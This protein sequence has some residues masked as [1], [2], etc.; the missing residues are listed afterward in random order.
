ML[1]ILLLR[2]DL[3]ETFLDSYRA[4]KAASVYVTV[5]SRAQ[6]EYLTKEMSDGF[7][8]VANLNSSLGEINCEIYILLCYKLNCVLRK[9]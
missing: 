1:P 6:N 5:W 8:L 9:I 3:L 2:Q 4:L 7:S